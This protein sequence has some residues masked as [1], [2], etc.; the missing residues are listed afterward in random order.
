[1]INKNLLNQLLMML[2]MVYNTLQL[3]CEKLDVTDLNEVV[4]TLQRLTVTA[5]AYPRLEQVLR[6]YM[7]KLRFCV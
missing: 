1:M 3:F 5:E 2:C 6:L 7:Y 4:P